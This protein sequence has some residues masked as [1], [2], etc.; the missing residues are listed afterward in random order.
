MTNNLTDMSF[1]DNRYVDLCA[2]TEMCHLWQLFE[3][4][5]PQH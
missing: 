3:K 5:L 2:N 1:D 4:Y